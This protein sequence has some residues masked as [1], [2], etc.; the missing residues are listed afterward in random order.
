MEQQVAT[1]GFQLDFEYFNHVIK[2]SDYF[3]E[4]TRKGKTTCLTA[5]T[6]TSI[7]TFLLCHQLISGIT[8]IICSFY[9]IL[10]SYRDSCY[11][12]RETLFPSPCKSPVHTR[13]SVQ[14]APLSSQSRKF[15]R[16]SSVNIWMTSK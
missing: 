10:I 12:V 8:T 3:P 15:Y 16:L 14:P 1:V 4:N 7:C 13:P 11:T 6:E 9:A 5:V 2:L